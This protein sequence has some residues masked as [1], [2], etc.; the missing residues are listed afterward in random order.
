MIFFLFLY[1]SQQDYH[2]NI[3]INDQPDISKI[4]FSHKQPS[5]S[6]SPFSAPDEFIAQCDISKKPTEE[7][8]KNKQVT[9]PDFISPLVHFRTTRIFTIYGD[10]N[11]MLML[12]Y[13]YNSFFFS[14]ERY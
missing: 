4:S 1:K 7:K 6:V 5:R 3:S 11:S 2:A 14:F 10:E 13:I 12:K 8:K 9:K